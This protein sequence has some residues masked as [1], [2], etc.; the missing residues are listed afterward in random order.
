MED[1]NPRI[2]LALNLGWSIKDAL[3]VK[4][5]VPPPHYLC[6]T[7][8]WAATY[9]VYILN[10]GIEV[11]IPHWFR[12]D[13]V[14]LHGCRKP[15]PIDFDHQIEVAPPKYQNHK[16]KLASEVPPKY[17]KHRV[18]HPMRED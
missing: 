7:S 14:M 8:Q 3:G 18:I 16:I 1:L 13:H 17:Q 12:D 5:L 10:D 4:F 9:E 2:G 6:K 11:R 15:D